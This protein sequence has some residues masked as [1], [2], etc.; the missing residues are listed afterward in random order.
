MQALCK[1]RAKEDDV[2][3]LRGGTIG[4][5]NVFSLREETKLISQMSEQNKAKV[6][7][8][9]QGEHAKADRRKMTAEYAECNRLDAKEIDRANMKRI[10]KK[11]VGEQREHNNKRV[12]GLCKSD[13]K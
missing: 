1:T 10:S 2:F 9:K 13:A 4:T 12:H 5:E 3:S 11:H 6:E 7:R 8:I